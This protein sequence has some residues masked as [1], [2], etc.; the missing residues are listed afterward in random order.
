MQ[1]LNTLISLGEGLSS[2]LSTLVKAHTSGSHPP[3]LQFQEI[4]RCHLLAS[5]ST[6][7]S[8]YVCADIHADK[9]FVHIK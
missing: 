2:I 3:L 5:V 7:H 9:A 8:I 1:Q 4:W 6:R